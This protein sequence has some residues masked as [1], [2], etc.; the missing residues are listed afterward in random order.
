[1]FILHESGKGRDDTALVVAAGDTLEGIGGTTDGAA[2]MVELLRFGVLGAVDQFLKFPRIVRC[3]LLLFDR[4]CF[5]CLGELNQK[6]NFKEVR[7][8]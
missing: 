5:P 1:M 4:Q 2:Y 6:G 3:H 7:V 8:L